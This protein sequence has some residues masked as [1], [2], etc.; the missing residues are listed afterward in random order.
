MKQIKKNCSWPGLARY[1]LFTLACLVWGIGLA[2][3]QNIKNDRFW[4]TENSQPIYSQGGGIF[5]I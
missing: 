2:Q 4:S 1:M 5:Y 3:M